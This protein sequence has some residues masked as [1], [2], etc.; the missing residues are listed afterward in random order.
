MHA[1]AG[2][3]LGVVVAERGD[4]A[5]GARLMLEHGGG[6]G[7]H[8]L[9]GPWRAYFLDLLT[10]ALLAAGRREEAAAAA[11]EALAFA[12]ATGLGLPTLAGRRASAR[13]ALEPD[14]AA[15]AEHALAAAAVA[16][17]IGTPVEAAL[18]RTLAGSALIA[19]GEPDRAEAEL[20]HAAEAFEA[21][22]VLRGRD[23]AERELRR[24]GRRD[25]HRRTR[26]GNADAG[27]LEA[28]TER[29]LQVARLI[30]DRRTNPQIAAEL[31]L[32]QK[33]VE[34]H[35]RHLFQKLGVSSRVEVAR[36]VERADRQ[37]L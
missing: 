17:E 11:R 6:A 37:G 10:A 18:A 16:D 28:L 35:V 1:F 3:V 21:R 22:G 26:A 27:G 20:V 7:L 8:G 29:E 32:S 30:V 15:A 12:E 36:A 19:A 33:T 25:L 13:V 4:P 23:A 14:P 34:T 5:D 9:P 31:F 2:M 24:L